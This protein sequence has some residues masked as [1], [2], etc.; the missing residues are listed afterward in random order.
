MLII[1]R[2][3]INAI[4]KGIRDWEKLTENEKL[5]VTDIDFFTP[6]TTLWAGNKT[7]G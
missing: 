7:F 5:R 2:H 1:V 6:V 4:Q 3:A